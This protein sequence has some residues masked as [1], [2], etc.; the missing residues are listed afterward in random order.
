MF[1]CPEEDKES[2]AVV[3]DRIS[4]LEILDRRQGFR[5][6]HRKSTSPLGLGSCSSCC[7]L[8][9][10]RNP[11]GTPS[12]VV[13]VVVYDPPLNPLPAIEVSSF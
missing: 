2:S 7:W 3:V 11:L 4:G 1:T 13:V 12:L 9:L 5:C 8:D 10:N 6:P